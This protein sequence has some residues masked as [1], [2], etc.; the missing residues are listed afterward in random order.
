MVYFVITKWLWSTSGYVRVPHQ[1]LAGLRWA[2][3]NGERIAVAYDGSIA[4]ARAGPGDLVMAGIH[5]QLTRDL[6]GPLRSA[7]DDGAKQDH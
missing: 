3:G 1:L 5:T 2:A 6:R 7:K 4:T